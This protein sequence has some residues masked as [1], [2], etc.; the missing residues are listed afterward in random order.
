VQWPFADFLMSPWARN[1][2]FGAKYFEYFQP[3]TS[4]Y[5]RY[6]FFAGETGAPFREELALALAAAILTTRMG[7]AAGNWMRRVQ[8]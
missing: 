6:R 4:M 1:W 7:I 2:F 5:V 8:R 3:S